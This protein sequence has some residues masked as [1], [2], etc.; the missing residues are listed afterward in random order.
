[1]L[2]PS[3]VL[4]AEQVPIPLTPSAVPGPV[5]GNEM[6]ADYVQL[7][8][9]MAYVWGYAMVNAHNRRAAFSEAPEPGL[10]GGIVPVAPIG[11]NSML[12]DYVD[13]SERFIVCP[14]QDVVYGTGFTDLAKE[15]SV[16]QVPDFGDRFWVYALY[17][18]RTDEIGQ[19][20]KQY[21]TEPGFYMIVGR[22]WQGEVPQGIKGVVRSS[23]DAVFTVPRIFKEATPEDTAAVQ[24]L[25]NQVVFYPLS[26]YDG[27]MKIKDWS[28]SPIFPTPKESGKGET[29]WVQPGKFFDQLPVVMEEVPP[30][31]G[32]EALYGWIASVWAAADRNTET[33]KVLVASFEAADKELVDPLFAFKYNGRDIGNG[34][35]APANASQWGT[36]YLNRTAISKSSMYQNTPEETQYQF[37]E[38]DS[39]GA[40][41]DG[42][43][44]YTITF[45]K[46]ETP[47]VKGFWSLTLYNA[48]HFFH[49]N[50]LG[51]YSR[52]TKDKALQ[53]GSDGSLT[54]YIGAAS[55]GKDKETNWLPA[56][57]GEFSLLMRNYWPEE[58]IIDG[59][60][61]PPDV[62]KVN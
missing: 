31:P 56:P 51:V 7:V 6:T 32:E 20:G 12:T 19:F 29:G 36:D 43:N 14:N 35:T 10:L 1:M 44:Q 8:G 37:K 17:D 39:I 41:L 26:E 21:G 48:E 54:L 34:W 11:Y 38:T 47:P 57:E 23:T 15:P 46:D 49:P 22:N 3:A 18:Q 2:S 5:P 42:N 27:R 50:P 30:L 16:F 53:Y 40:L 55:P 33:K 13:P 28:K 52:G 4:S 45:P 59:T 9:R 60:W 61:V 58:S 62:V 25:I 24:A